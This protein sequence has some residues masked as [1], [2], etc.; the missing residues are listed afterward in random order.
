M[1]NIQNIN[2]AVDLL[3]LVNPWIESRVYINMATQL[4]GITTYTL[5]ELNY[6]EKEAIYSLKIEVIEDNEQ[7][8]RIDRRFE[9]EYCG[10]NLINFNKYDIPYIYFSD[11]KAP[12]HISL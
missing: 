10:G 8:F 11:N 6:D 12:F 1:D 2:T 3:N 7:N 5:D 4:T 9:E